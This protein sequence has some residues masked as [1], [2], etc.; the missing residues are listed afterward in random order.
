MTKKVLFVSHLFLLLALW[1]LAFSTNGTGGGGDSLTHFFFAKLS[2]QEPSNFFN[3][4]GKPFFTIM[5]SPWAQFGF[6][7]MKLFNVLCGVGSSYLAS[8]VAFKLVRPWA[9]AIPVLAFASPAYYTFLFSGLTEPFSSLVV[10]GAVYLC[11]SHRV[12]WGFI[13]ASFLPFCRSEA[14]VFLLFFILF[15]MINGNWKKLPLLLLGYIIIGISGLLY[16]KSVFWIFQSPYNPQGSVYGQ[17]DWYHYIAELS[18]MM[19]LP[20]LCLAGL[21]IIQFFRK[22]LVAKNFIWKTELWLVHGI[23]FSLLVGHSLVWALGIYGSAGLSRTLI[24]VFPL[25][26]LICLD[27]LILIKDLSTILFKGRRLILPITTLV[28]QC[29][30]LA[31]SPTTR[32]YYYTH[33]TLG[34]ENKFI[35]AEVA[36]FVKSNYPDCKRFVIDKPYLALAFGINFIN[37]DERWSWSS[38]SHLHTL[39]EDALFIFDEQYVPVQYGISLEHIRKEKKLRELHQWISPDGLQYVLFEAP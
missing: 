33:L 21:G 14:Q 10:I 13:L 31:T 7:G 27:G 6:I 23:F 1:L 2:W 38:Y 34:P 35:N 32:Y 20:F 29:W 36:P 37:P 24:T 22:A 16:H 17:G 8:L 12:G 4:W 18:K 11:L 15:G 26:W 28:L 39:P 5:A 3:H 25:L 19:G 9:W 30:V